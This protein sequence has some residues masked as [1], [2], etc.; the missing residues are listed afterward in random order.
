M[1]K[2]FLFLKISLKYLIFLYN[3]TA[4]FSIKYYY[5]ICELSFTVKSQELITSFLPTSKRVLLS[6]MINLSQDQYLYKPSN[7]EVAYITKLL[8]Y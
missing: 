6:K 8:S 2:L 5:E 4:Y 7:G 1:K 3:Y